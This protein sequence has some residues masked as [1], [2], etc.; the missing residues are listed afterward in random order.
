MEL[1]SRQKGDVYT[2]AGEYPALRDRIR[3]A[4]KG[5]NI[6][7]VVVYAF[8]KRTRLLPF[9]FSSHRMAPAG[10]R[11][12]GAALHDSGLTQTRIVLQQWTPNFQPS[13]ASLDGEPIEMLLVSSMQIHAERAYGLVADACTKP[14]A[15]R[16]L[17]I[18]GGPKAIYEPS[19]L[20]EIGG[21]PN[22]TADVVVTGEEF[23]LMQL[24]ERLLNYRGTRGTMREAFFAARSDGALVDIPGLV[25][26]RDYGIDAPLVTTGIQRLVGNLDEMPHPLIGYKLLERPH[27]KPGLNSQPLPTSRVGRHSI[28]GS[29]TIS[30][31]CKFNCDY[32]PIPAY[33]QRT[34][35]HKSGERIVDEMRQLRE[36]L[37]IR[38]F[39]GTDD[40]FFNN[41][42]AVEQMFETMSRATIAGRPLR[43]AVRWGTEAT[44]FDTWKNRDLLG[45]GRRSGLR[46]LWLGIED[47][48]ATLIR[49]GQSVSKTADLFALMNKTGIC[50]MPMMM[51]HDGQPLYT[52]GSLYGL[53]NQIAYLRKHGVQSVQVTALT[54]AVG[55]RS[56]EPMFENGSVFES[57]GNR[58]VRQHQFDGNHVVATT[59]T[60]PWRGQLNVLLAY[61]SY[62]N[63]INFVRSLLRPANSLYLAGLSDQLR[64]MFAL[65]PTA[66]NSVHWAFRLWRGPIKRQTGPPV[67]KIPVI[68]VS[69]AITLRADSTP[70]AARKSEFVQVGVRQPR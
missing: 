42:P 13:R 7:T 46:A 35:R 45:P 20:F 47:L 29:L 24:V 38:F 18:V 28:I 40:N 36:Q 30:H 1:P 21:D 66:L 12:V 59:S 2:K 63:P 32:C 25:Y 33:N 6:P 48:T 56:Y 8:D 68:D 37:G 17:I 67:S 60:K 31:G 3:A 34:Y 26:R 52:R 22:V 49:K 55:T 27:R 5:L 15:D 14:A 9:F 19:D 65:V 64:G 10:P 43:K 41:R 57:V 62:Y 53:L 4:A 16:P 54:P 23:V 11:A 39:F 69:P 51:H 58:P 70:Q 44:E 61:A 50:P